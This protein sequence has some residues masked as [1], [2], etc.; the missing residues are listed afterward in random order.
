MLR[1]RRSARGVG[2]YFDL[3]TDD[4]RLFYGDSFHFGYFAQGTETLVEAL[5]AHTDLVGELARIV[6][7]TK[8][9]DLGC[10][11]GA[12]AARIA[13]RY[14]CRVTGVNISREQVRQGRDLIDAIGLSDQVEIRLGNALAIEFP[15]ESL[16]AVLCIEVAADI[17]VTDRARDQLVAEIWRVLRPGGH[18]GFSDLALIEVPSPSEDRALRAVCYHSGSELIV[19]WPSRFAAQS[20]C[21][22]EE[23]DIHAATMPTWGHIEGV[24][25]ERA[26][27]VDQRYGRCL[28]DR[29]RR[30]LREVVPMIRQNGRFPALCL[31][32]PS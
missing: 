29:T 15:D 2:A 22:I 26:G 30:Q 19:D 10:G 6:P 1:R 28:A 7:G 8:V 5:D 20:F 14:D 25:R 3:I 32:R 24:Y 9:L 31:Q 21:V 18:V 16:D 17:C 27:E 4:G 11:I 23:R 12:P 13:R